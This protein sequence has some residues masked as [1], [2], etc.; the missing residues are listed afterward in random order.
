MGL[1]KIAFI[2][3]DEVLTISYLFIY[4]HVRQKVCTCPVNKPPV[5][6]LPSFTQFETHVLETNSHFPPEL[7]V[8]APGDFTMS[9]LAD[10]LLLLE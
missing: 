5:V 9:N 1:L 3:L 10:T 6:Q 2:E 8:C 7:S 4:W